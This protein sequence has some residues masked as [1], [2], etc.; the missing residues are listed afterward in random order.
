MIDWLTTIKS[1]SPK[2]YHKCRNYLDRLARFG[3]ELRRPISDYLRDGVYELRI[4]HLGI[5]YRV[6]YGFVGK[7]VVLVSHGFTKEKAVPPTEIEL[8]L[9]RLAKFRKNPAAHTSSEEY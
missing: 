9:R 7:N 4:R 5:N 1:R 2:A 3:N 8:A 6:L